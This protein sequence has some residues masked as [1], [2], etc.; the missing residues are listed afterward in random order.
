MQRLIILLIFL[1]TGIMA[2]ADCTAN[3]IYCWPNTSAVKSNPVFVLTF[4]AYSQT[5]VPGLNKQ[6]SIYLKSG[7]QKVPLLIS[8]VYQGQF[9]LTQVILKP[10]RQLTPGKEYQLVIDSLPNHDGISKWNKELRKAELPKWKVLKEADTDLPAW[11]TLP[12]YQS[13]SIIYFGCGP[14]LSVLFGF[15][16]TDESDILIKTTVRNTLTGKYTTYYLEST[17]KTNISV[18]H[19]MCSGAFDFET[20]DK[21]EVS[22]EL[23]DASGNPGCIASTP[24]LFTRPTKK[25]KSE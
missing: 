22:F 14:S 25:D 5:I 18:G 19:D 15:G 2:K 7:E 8:E 6:Y 21:Y 20:D 9:R 4:Y 16:A 13:K 23:M 10:A 12:V 24:I 3:G 11:T 17:D 1:F